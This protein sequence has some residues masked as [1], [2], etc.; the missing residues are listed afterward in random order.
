MADIL[1]HK[2]TVLC[3]TGANIS[4]LSKKI[5]DSWP[6]LDKP[7]L[8][9]VNSKMVTVTGERKSFEGKC[10]VPIQLGNHKFQHKILVADIV[11]DGILGIDFMKQNNCDLMIS[12]NY[13]KVNGD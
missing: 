12:K 7:N 6:K 13:L 2:V 4:I 5:F 8:M 3:D 9:P 11:Q 1:G 10:L